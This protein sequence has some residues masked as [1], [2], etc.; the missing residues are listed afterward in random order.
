MLSKKDGKLSISANNNCSSEALQ[1]PKSVVSKF[2]V[3]KSVEKFIAGSNADKQYI[4]TSIAE[5][6]KKSTITVS[7]QVF[8]YTEEMSTVTTTCYLG[9]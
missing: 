4:A 9:K 8:S 6:L 3:S 2:D 7:R 1:F 5:P